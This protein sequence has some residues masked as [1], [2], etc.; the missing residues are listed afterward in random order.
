VEW[1]RRAAS[2][3]VVRRKRLRGGVATTS[4]GFSNVGLLAV[5]LIAAVCGGILHGIDVLQVQM[6]GKVVPF[7]NLEHVAGVLK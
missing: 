7:T 3:Q 2:D 6:N 5:D 4:Y 1:P